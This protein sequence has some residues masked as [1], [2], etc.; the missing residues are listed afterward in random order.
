MDKKKK[1][2]LYAPIF[3]QLYKQIQDELERQC[4]EVTFIPDVLQNFN[5]YFSTC[6][7]RPIKKVYYNLY[8][9]N[10]KY[11]QQY[12]AEIEQNYD[13]FI[14][15]NGFS[16]H[17]SILAELRRNNPN[18][19]AILYL[20]DSVSYFDFSKSFPYFDS[21]FSFDYTDAQKENLK[22]LPLYWIQNSND[23]LLSDMKYGLSFIGT[24]HTDRLRIIR[25]IIEQ[26][27]ELKINHFIKLVYKERRLSLFDPI[28]Y[29]YYK[30]KLTPNAIGYIDEY[31]VLRGKI[32]EDYLCN[33]SF[34]GS[35]VE[36]I[37]Q[38]SS[39]I[40]DVELPYQTGL[41]NRMISSMGN[42]KKIITTNQAVKDLPFW[43]KNNICC[44]ERESPILNKDFICSEYVPNKE[45]TNYLESLRIDNWV[46]TLLYG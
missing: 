21:I 12:K 33:T 11:L 43:D 27:G 22:Y 40:L 23:K 5:P 13:Y 36:S 6:S 2:L 38:N 18:I 25:K 20:W 8:E 45:V 19:K 46:K 28:R 7:F 39:C 42:K 24:L 29:L 37:M 14:C 44:I 17:P 9:P 4:Y 15:I 32:R 31:N 41:T 26:C 30:T 16:F 10:L 1:V 35:V 34:T 3:Y